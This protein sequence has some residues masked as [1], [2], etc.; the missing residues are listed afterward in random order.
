MS[1]FPIA[2]HNPLF[3]RD[4]PLL[5]PVPVTTHMPLLSILKNRN[6]PK[7]TR[8]VQP[9]LTAK[10]RRNGEFDEWLGLHDAARPAEKLFK[11]VTLSYVHRVISPIDAVVAECD[12]A[13]VKLVRLALE[14]RESSVFHVAC[15]RVLGNDKGSIVENLFKNHI[16]LRVAEELERQDDDGL[17][18]HRVEAPAKPTEKTPSPSTV[19]DRLSTTGAPRDRTQT[20]TWAAEARAEFYLNPSELKGF[21]VELK[22][23]PMTLNAV[24]DALQRGGVL[25]ARL[26]VMRTLDVALASSCSDDDSGQLRGWTRAIA[27]RSNM[28]YNF[29][30]FLSPSGS[31]DEQKKIM[32]A[33]GFTLIG[34]GGYSSV[35]A[36]N[37]S[38]PTKILPPVLRRAIHPRDVAFKTSVDAGATHP[39]GLI[40]V[41]EEIYNHLLAAFSGCAP[42]VVACFVLPSGS[43]AKPMYSSLLVT[44][45]YQSNLVTAIDNG[46][47]V[48]EG[49]SIVG[50]ER[51]TRLVMAAAFDLS[52]AGI[53]NLDLKPANLVAQQ[54]NQTL[55]DPEARLKRDLFSFDNVRR[56]GLIDLDATFC[57]RPN[58]LDLK[59]KAAALRCIF[60]VNALLLLAHLKT[61]DVAVVPRMLAVSCTETELAHNFN[62]VLRNAAAAAAKNHAFPHDHFCAL[63]VNATFDSPIIPFR[64]LRERDSE[65]IGAQMKALVFH[66]FAREEAP[67][68][69]RN[70]F[71]ARLDKSR[72]IVDIL[73]EF[74]FGVRILY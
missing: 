3:E 37:S 16:S 67:D 30:R 41:Y 12:E 39:R 57:I 5:S 38:T 2:A 47:T 64:Y 7:A 40:V 53:V 6:K 56:V 24:V 43:I 18:I 31:A 10:D 69:A 61:F 55:L 44:E 28:W 45:R 32:A 66:Y 42:A 73:H 29:L 17:K 59:D 14:R 71:N 9:R 25:E 13:L 20:G 35:Y 62:T 26:D 49:R 50:F 70:F 33:R 48:S 21:Q 11:F 58:I 8:V 46:L 63:L 51:F 4:F 27:D 34:L 72:P 54:F 22:K 23:A 65:A 60:V 68:D 15:V 36:T 1:I 52:V 19:V 74:V